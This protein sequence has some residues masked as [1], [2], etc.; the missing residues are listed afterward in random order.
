VDQGRP[1][2]GPPAVFVDIDGQPRPF[3][4]GFDIG[5]FEVQTTP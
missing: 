5:A 1:L 2:N 3:G 4:D